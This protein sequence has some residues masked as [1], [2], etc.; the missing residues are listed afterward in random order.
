M[1]RASQEHRGSG[2]AEEAIQ[3]LAALGQHLLELQ[4]AVA[5]LDPGATDDADAV[6][7]VEESSARVSEMH[8]RAWESSVRVDPTS[9]RR[10]LPAHTGDQTRG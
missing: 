7:I 3:A 2:H 6:R 9:S 8:L 4:G 5:D 10:L 1:E